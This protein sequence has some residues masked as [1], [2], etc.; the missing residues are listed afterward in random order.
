MAPRRDFTGKVNY[1][2]REICDDFLEQLSMST[3]VADKVKELVPKAPCLKIGEGLY[4]KGN[5]LR[6]PQIGL[7]GL[8][9]FKV[10][11]GMRHSL[12]LMNSIWELDVGKLVVPGVFMDVDLLTQIA[13]NYGPIMLGI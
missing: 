11:F 8:G 10:G 6:D 9:L 12:A 3:N 7:S 1:Q 5:C 2:E 4:Y 13:H